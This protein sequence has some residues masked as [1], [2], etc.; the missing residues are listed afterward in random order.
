MGGGWLLALPTPLGA[1]ALTVLLWLWL[2]R[3]RPLATK[4]D[5]APTSTRSEPLPALA[6]ACG[7][8]SCLRCYGLRQ[9]DDF[10]AVAAAL[11]LSPRFGAMVAALREGRR[12]VS[13]RAPVQRPTLLFCPGLRCR[14]LWPR[15]EAPWAAVLERGAAGVAAEFAT[16]RQAQP[17]LFRRL[18]AR[19][20][21]GG[22]G[23]GGGGWRGGAFVDQGREVA[24]MQAACPW[25]WALLRRCGAM[26]GCSLGYAFFSSLAPGM[27]IEEHCGSSN[28][29]LRAHLALV[30]PP[31]SGAGRMHL[32]V[33]GDRLHWEQHRCA[34]FDDSLQ[35]SVQLPAGGIGE[36][37]QQQE[38]VV[39]VVDL[40]HPD[41]TQG[42]IG[43][44]KALFPP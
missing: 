7:M 40:Y 29:K 16:V 24:A 12:L 27:A 14:P 15:G 32:K 13:S 41:L 6:D 26:R 33:G 36:A 10:E 23:G 5:S 2:R 20:A 42:E 8:L 17:A 22:G 18:P 25:T 30:V 39:L 9:T 3:R 37:D 35:H 31:Q 43:A 11:S 1:L 38:R 34:T 19:N 44:L 4:T 28:L 21:H